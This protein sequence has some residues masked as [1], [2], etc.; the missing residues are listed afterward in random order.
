MNAATEIKNDVKPGIT[1]GSQEDFL[2]EGFEKDFWEKGYCV[3][4]QVFSA[5]EMKVM[6]EATDRV[7]EIGIRHGQN[8]RHANLRYWVEPDPVIGMNVRGMQWPAHL[9]PSL[10]A[11][12]VDPRIF[13]IL[14][15]LIGD[16]VKQIIN[17][18]HWKTPGSRM[19]VNYHIDR[20]N[21]LPKT[22]FRHLE[23][24][25]VQTGLAV[26][27]QTSENGALKVLPGSHKKLG[28][29]TEKDLNGYDNKNGEV[30]NENLVR[31]GY[32]WN[33]LV[34]VI[35]EPGDLAIWHVDLIHG[36]DLNRSKTMDRCLYING[37]V[38][39]RNSM[40]GQW[41]FIKGQ[42]IPLPDIDVPVLVQLEDIFENLEP[43]YMDQKAKLAD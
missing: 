5:D 34:E 42:S 38:D 6:H 26:D 23:K 39:A 8:F 2:Y 9:E 30:T 21:R 4:R 20:Q 11:M 36:S 7:K 1:G 13:R 35:M 25:Y 32:D 15:P 29:L 19:S 37:Y 40:L 22:G 27:P 28:R 43:H 16:Q 3:F 10:E 31:W 14:Q 12:R 18:I 41:A 17:Q 33:Q 24:S